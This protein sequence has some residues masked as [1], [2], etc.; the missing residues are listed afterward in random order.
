MPTYA[1]SAGVPETE[2]ASLTP[3]ISCFVTVKSCEKY[4]KY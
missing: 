2:Y 3:G 1:Q 4:V